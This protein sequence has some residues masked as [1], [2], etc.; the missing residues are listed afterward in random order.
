MGHWTKYDKILRD[1]SKRGY[2]VAMARD[3]KKNPMLFEH[4]GWAIYNNKI[5]RDTHMDGA[6]LTHTG[7]PCDFPNWSLL[8]NQAKD[9]PDPGFTCR[10]CKTV[11]SFEGYIMFIKVYRMINRGR[12]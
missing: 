11:L 1:Y 7:C 6:I 2:D 12:C 3:A 8:S 10:H 9:L 5:L 4:E